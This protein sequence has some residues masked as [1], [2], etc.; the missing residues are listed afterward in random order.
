MVDFMGPFSFPQSQKYYNIVNT[1]GYFKCLQKTPS[2]RGLLI[3]LENPIAIWNKE[4]PPEVLFNVMILR[5]L[6][7]H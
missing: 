7:L 6:V 3:T 1:L 4:I 5:K 2:P